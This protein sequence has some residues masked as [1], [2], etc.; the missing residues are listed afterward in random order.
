MNDDAILLA[1]RETGSP[2]N[3]VSVAQRLRGLLGGVL[4]QGALIS[5][6]KRAFPLIPLR[7]LL[8]AGGWQRVSNGG[9]SDDDFNALLAPWLASRDWA[10]ALIFKYLAESTR[11]AQRLCGV[12]SQENLL[13]GRRNGAIPRSGSLEGVEFEFHGVGCRIAEGNSSAD[14]DFLPD[15]QLGGFDAW[16]LHVFS[17][18]NPGLAPHSQSEIQGALDVLETNAVVER[19]SGSSLYRFQG[20]FPD[21]G[22]QPS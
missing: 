19:V 12:Y 14:F 2:R 22:A 21:A 5:Y 1:I 18:A 8:D 16:R 11:L 10:V 7:V 13:A 17:E 20:G 4:T 9:L 3:A 15:G 6:F